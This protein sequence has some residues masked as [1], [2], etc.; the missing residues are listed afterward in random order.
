V[1]DRLRQGGTASSTTAPPGGTGTAFLGVTTSQAD[2]GAGHPNG[3]AL[4][5]SVSPGTPAAQAGLRSGDVIVAAGGRELTGPDDLR[6]A[7]SSHRPG[8]KVD[9]TWSRGGAQQSA[10]VTLASR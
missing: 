5:G 6:S 8:D 10:T 9:I 2:T 1:L 3:G 7:V 4:V